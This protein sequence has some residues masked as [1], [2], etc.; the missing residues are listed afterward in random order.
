[1]EHFFERPDQLVFGLETASE[2]LDRF[3]SAVRHALGNEPGDTIIVSHGTV[4]SL[5]LGSIAGQN[6]HELW[7]NLKM[8]DLI[9]VSRTSL[10]A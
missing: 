3:K 5:L 1:M 10:G 9:E 8:P 2:A 4:L 7:R 6:C